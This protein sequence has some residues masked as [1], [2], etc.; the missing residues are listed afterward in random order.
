MSVR[1]ISI[2]DFLENYFEGAILGRPLGGQEPL[3][4]DSD[5]DPPNSRVRPD[6]TATWTKGMSDRH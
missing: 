5:S 4:I 1:N 6:G 2:H 3:P